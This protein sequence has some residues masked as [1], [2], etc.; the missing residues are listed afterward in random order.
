V[1]GCRE[2]VTPDVNGWL[3]PARHG[4]AW[5]GH[6]RRVRYMNAGDTT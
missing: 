4:P 5:W 6:E 2:T 3:V 1:P